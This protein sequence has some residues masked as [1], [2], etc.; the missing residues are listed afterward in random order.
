MIAGETGVR[1]PN[2]PILFAFPSSLQCSEINLS[3]HDSVSNVRAL[4]A[5]K[6]P[7]CCAIVEL[8]L[9]AGEIAT[10]KRHRRKPDRGRPDRVPLNAKARLRRQ[11]VL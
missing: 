10:A 9:H 4:V 8:S 5:P 1:N 3:V 6:E 11:G 2:C 7:P